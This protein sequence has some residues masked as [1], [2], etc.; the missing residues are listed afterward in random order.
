[1][2]DERVIQV[3]GHGEVE[4]KPDIAVLTLGVFRRETMARAAMQGASETMR[5][6]IA[7]A[8]EQG[9]PD[10]DI[11][12]SGLNLHPDQEANLY[13]VQQQVTVRVGDVAKAGAILDAAVEAGANAS[14]AIQFALADDTE[15]QDRALE[16]AVA[17]ARRKAET[18]AAALGVAIDRVDGVVISDGH[19]M[20]GPSFARRIR[21]GGGPVPIEGGQIRVAAEVQVTYSVR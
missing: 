19:V 2:P 1:M 18:V 13:V 4:V 6:I 16:L 15:L 12:T 17:D 11:Q 21:G 3:Q 5:A 20:P 10:H 7:A 8:R 14:G 9:V